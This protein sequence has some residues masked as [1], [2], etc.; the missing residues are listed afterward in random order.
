MNDPRRSIPVALPPFC[1]LIDEYGPLVW[2]YVASVAGPVD[3]ADV[4][5]ETLLAALRAYP[6]LRDASNLRSWLM[7]IAHNKVIDRARAGARQPV[8]VGAVPEHADTRAPTTG[9]D[10]ELWSAVRRLPEKQRSSVVYR[11]VDDLPY[12][13]IGRIVGC[14]E[15]AARQNV[16]AGLAR[17]REELA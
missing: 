8:P 5:Q 15:A 11:F 14:S 17:L 10:E 13:E 6:S 4:Y 12:A 7:T 9:P 3:G 16:R 1:T 2:R